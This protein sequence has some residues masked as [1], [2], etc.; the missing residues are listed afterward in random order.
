MNVQRKKFAGK[1]YSIHTSGKGWM[2]RVNLL[3][4]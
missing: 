4:N 3:M 2:Q 1:L